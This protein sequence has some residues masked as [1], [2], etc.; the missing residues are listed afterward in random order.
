MSLK[1][2]LQILSSW[3]IPRKWQILATANPDNGAYSVT[4][5]DDAMLTRMLHVTLT[6]DAKAWAA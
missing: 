3:S 1:N 4:P 5:M 2:I 6:F